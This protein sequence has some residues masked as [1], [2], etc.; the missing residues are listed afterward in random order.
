MEKNITLSL[1]L[2]Q[3]ELYLIACLLT[4][5][6]HGQKDKKKRRRLDKQILK[7][8]PRLN[9]EMAYQYHLNVMEM[10]WV[11]ASKMFPKLKRLAESL[12]KK[13]TND[14]LN[15]TYAMILS[16]ANGNDERFK[17]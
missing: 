15:Q 10:D 14:F 17:K 5:A 11:K 12:K 9:Y 1:T 7:I 13:N 2:S 16:V 6:V 3:I 8:L 4:G